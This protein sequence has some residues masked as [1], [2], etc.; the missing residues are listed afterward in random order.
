MKGVFVMTK[1]FAVTALAVSLCGV[2]AA[3]S[4]GDH[5]DDSDGARNQGWHRT[6]SAPEITAGSAAAALALLAGSLAVLR[7]RKR[8]Q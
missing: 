4:R 5:D 6:V 8:G 2:A 1:L 7:G 3:H